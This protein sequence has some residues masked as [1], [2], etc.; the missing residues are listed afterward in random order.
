MLLAIG[1][2]VLVLCMRRRAR[3]LASATR[4]EPG[5]EY[6]VADEPVQELEVLQR[7][8]MNAVVGRAGRSELSPGI[9]EETRGM[10][11]LDGRGKKPK[12]NYS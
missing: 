4:Q 9:S 7:A 8:E 1:S 6:Q 11:E 5:K 12:R 2:A 10:L 3:R